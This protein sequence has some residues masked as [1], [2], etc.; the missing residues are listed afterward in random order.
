VV[1]QQGAHRRDGTALRKALYELEAAELRLDL[2]DQQAA[3]GGHR[4]FAKVRRAD[5]D[6]ALA[7][8]PARTVVALLVPLL[9]GDS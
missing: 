3:A 8:V 1:G 4:S 2:E 6:V 5:Q 7:L 9:G